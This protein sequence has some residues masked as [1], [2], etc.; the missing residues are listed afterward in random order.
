M[1]R[2]KALVLSMAVIFAL[3]GIAL[4]RDDHDNRD[5]GKKGYQQGYDRGYQDGQRAARDDRYH[6]N[7]AN[8]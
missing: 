7:D 1:R 4:A 6:H 8:R 3:S 5:H 2:I